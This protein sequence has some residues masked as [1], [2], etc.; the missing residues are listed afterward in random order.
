MELTFSCF[1]KELRVNKVLENLADV[2]NVCLL[3]QEKMRTS[4]R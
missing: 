3:I 4:S 1:T 2:V